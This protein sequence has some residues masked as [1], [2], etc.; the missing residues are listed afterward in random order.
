MQP[1]T[2]CAAQELA[3]F[4]KCYGPDTVMRYYAFRFR[5]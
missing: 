1:V 2:E 4:A 5:R 3:Q